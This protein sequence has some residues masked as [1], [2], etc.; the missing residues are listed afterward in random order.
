[1]KTMRYKKPM[2]A[3]AH[4]LSK[5]SLKVDSESEVYIFLGWLK[6]GRH[7]YVINH[8]V[9]NINFS[10]KE[11]TKKEISLPSPDV[12]SVFAILGAAKAT[13]PKRTRQ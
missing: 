3:N 8:Y 7:T 6:P 4:W 13:T 11:P 5:E 10:L 9:D 12:L 2:V 1:M